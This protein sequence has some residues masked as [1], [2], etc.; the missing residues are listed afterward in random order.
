MDRELGVSEVQ[1]LIN[2]GQTELLRSGQEGKVIEPVREW[3]G[4][5]ELDET[6]TVP[7][8]SVRIARC[9]VVRRGDL[10]VAKSP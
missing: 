1:H 9:Q 3:E 6:V 2:A 10:A 7:P 8:L 5:V 4:T